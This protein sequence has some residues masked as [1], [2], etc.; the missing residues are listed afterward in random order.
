MIRI[1][2]RSLAGQM[3]T[4]LLLALV[5]LQAISVF[6]FL[7]ERRHAVRAADR[8]Q[9]LSRT[10]SIVRL[11]GDIPAELS[12]RIVE[13]ASGPRLRYWLAQD[14][15]VA[16]GDAAHR[17]NPLRKHLADM[18]DGTQARNVLV[19]IETAAP[20]AFR[21]WDRMMRRAWRS[22]MH[23]GP[24]NG[25]DGHDDDDDGDDDD[26]DSA[27]PWRWRGQPYPGPLSLTIAVQLADARWL[28]AAT[29]LPPAAPAWAWS[30]LTWLALMAL[31]V[32]LIVV[33]SVRRITRP[34]RALAGAAERLGRGEE[35]PPLAEEGPRE[36]RQTAQAFNVMVERLQRFVRDRTRMLAAVSHDLRTPITSLRLRAEFVEDPEAREKILETL[37]E[38]QEMVEAVLSF[39]REDAAREETRPMDLTALIA[40]LCDDLAEGGLDV[41]YSE[42]QALHYHCRPVSLKRALTNVIENAAA[43][44]DRARVA[45]S[46]LDTAYE[47]TVDDDGPGI[48]EADL[49]RVF[50]AFLRLE[51]SR[52]RDT[53]G[54][55]LGLAIARSIVRGHGGDIT[56]TN[57]PGGGLR[58]TIRL[59][60][61]RPEA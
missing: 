31:A 41:R 24:M 30:T 50:D 17:D 2:P 37:A 57:R 45:V 44:G 40:S 49:E 33:F 6:L 14:S 7:D 39:A 47:I 4:L 42:T 8:A 55:G 25:H 5:A 59:P 58:A 43:Y 32:T 35:V 12:D 11:L 28:N 36:V 18:L 56:L 29:L 48:P 51:A 52:S 1:W 46:S 3:I 53:G 26:D 13:T 54:A 27:H 34:M 19:R 23:R 10:L 22:R 20:D 60:K 61:H 15:A 9:V 16:P 38:M 21:P